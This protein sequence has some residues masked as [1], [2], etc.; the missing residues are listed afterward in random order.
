MKLPSFNE[1]LLE[2]SSLTNHQEVSKLPELISVKELKS[3]LSSSNPVLV[4]TGGGGGA[5][6]SFI[7]KK[8]F[9]K[10][11]TIDSD[12]Y[13]EKMS[14]G[15]GKWDP[16]VGAKARAKVVKDFD[17]FLSK[18]KSFIKQGIS[19]N[20]NALIGQLN[21]SRSIGEHVNVFLYVDT[22]LKTAIKRSKQRFDSG[23]RKNILPDWKVQKKLEE[24]RKVYQEILKLSDGFDYVVYVKN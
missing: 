22:D 20:I 21:K 5:G 8:H 2:A 3:L 23:E 12:E 16:K 18:K 11:L 24:S 4:L 6:K 19:A 17:E 14:G 10:T 1:F 7:V 13:V 9:S 15:D